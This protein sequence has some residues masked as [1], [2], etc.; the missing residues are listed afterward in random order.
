M[1]VNVNNTAAPRGYSDVHELTSVNSLAQTFDDDGNQLT[2][3]NGLSLSWSDANRL[4]ST[5]NGPLTGTY[6]YDADNKRVRKQVTDSGTT[7]ID[8]IYIHVG[9]NCVAEYNVDDPPT[10]P[11]KE[12]VYGQT[13]DSLVLLSRNNDSESYTVTRN[14]QWSAT[15]LASTNDGSIAER[16][17]YDQFG[18]RTILESNGST[19]RQSSSL[20]M[21]YGYTSRRYDDE[22][23]LIYFRAR[24]YDPTTG[25]FTSR[26]PL[27]YVDGMS[28]MRGYLGIN[29]VDPN[30][31]EIAGIRYGKVC[32]FHSMDIHDNEGGFDNWRWRTEAQIA[33]GENGCM[34]NEPVEEPNEIFDFVKENDCC[35]IYVFG[36]RGGGDFGNKGAVTFA[37]GTDKDSPVILFPSNN[38]ELELA[39]KEQFSNNCDRCAINIVGCADD[40]L[41]HAQFRQNLANVTGCAVC[42]SSCSITL[43]GSE[44]DKKKGQRLRTVGDPAEAHSPTV[45]EKWEPLCTLPVWQLAPLNPG[46]CIAFEQLSTI[47]LENSRTPKK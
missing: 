26:D 6:Q 4:S 7:T 24:Y 44:V 36:H 31:Y 30:G 38:L 16:Y 14:Q 15:A 41:A 28:M 5:T 40:D 11:A 2:T 3:H 21:P 9:P 17:T 29:D 13:I 34:R 35:T 43:Q 18:K 1:E 20:D 33:K 37:P 27:E 12:Y 45:T 8:S 47:S 39:L 10:S 25:K 32:T 46:Q 42:Q 19:T 23:D 22:S